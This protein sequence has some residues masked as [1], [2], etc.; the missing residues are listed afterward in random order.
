MFESSQ[1]HM[2]LQNQNKHENGSM[3]P[4]NKSK[5]MTTCLGQQSPEDDAS[6]TTWAEEKKTQMQTKARAVRGKQ[7]TSPKPRGMSQHRIRKHSLVGV[8]GQ[9]SLLSAH[10]RGK[11]HSISRR[12]Q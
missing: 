8:G 10:A 11:K 1:E 9:D 2:G 12:Y 3:C 5:Q 4:R 6:R 7:M